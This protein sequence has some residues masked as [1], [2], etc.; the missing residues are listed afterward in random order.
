MNAFRA[1]ADLDLPDAPTD[2]GDGVVPP[3]PPDLGG[4]GGGRDLPPRRGVHGYLPFIVLGAGVIGVERIAM[5]IFNWRGLPVG[6]YVAAGVAFATVVGLGV[7]VG[8]TMFYRA[9]QADRR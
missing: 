9:Y 4:G 3:E 8:G 2:G 7:G 5:S 1:A 6:A